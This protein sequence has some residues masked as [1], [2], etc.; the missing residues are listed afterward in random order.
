MNDISERQLSVMIFFIPLVFKMCML[1]SYLYETAGVEGYVI[2]GLFALTEF[3]QLWAVLFV[4][5]KGGMKGI[6]ARYGDNVY[7]LIS[8]PLLFV[9]FIKSV[10][11]ITEIVHYLS[12]FLF[13]NIISTPIIVTLI[14][15]CYYFAYKGARSIARIFETTVW[16]IPVII[17][18]GLIFG[19]TNIR[20][21]CLL[22]VFPSG[23]AGVFRSVERYLIYTF[24]F[25]PLLF[26]NIKIRKKGAV[27]LFSMLSI[28]CLMGC[29]MLFYCRYGRA[30]HLIDCAFARLASFDTVISE[31][32]SLDWISCILWVTTAVLNLSLKFSVVAEIGTGL[33]LKRPILLGVF[34]AVLIFVLLRIWVNMEEAFFMATGG[35]QFAVFGVEI[36]VPF[37][38]LVLFS[39]QNRGGYYAP[40]L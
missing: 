7:R 26:F 25:S 4:C 31:V 24:D 32:G 2:V 39:V 40:Q 17:L 37:I 36:A 18:M 34:C 33:N 28:L 5:N 23:G 6:R 12:T 10:L 16:L 22:A 9:V 38:M 35:V 3:I 1:P 19:E 21:E 11:F 27:G 15:I 8:L 13:Y 20:G 14:L 30:S 29:Y